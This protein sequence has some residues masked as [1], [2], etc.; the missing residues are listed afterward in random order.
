M[1]LSILTDKAC[2]AGKVDLPFIMFLSEP[3]KV[4]VDPD[5][6]ATLERIYLVRDGKAIA[7]SR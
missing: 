1:E 4:M 6:S 7:L 5:E 3:A 2:S